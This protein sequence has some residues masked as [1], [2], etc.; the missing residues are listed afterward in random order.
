MDI[1]RLRK[2]R[3]YM[4]YLIAPD[5]LSPSEANHTINQI[6]A[7]KSLP[8][9]LYHDHFIGQAGGIIIFFAE[10]Q[11]EREA[12]QSGLEDYLVDWRYDVH[13]L[14]YSY[15]PAAFDAQIAYTLAAYRDNDWEQLQKEHRPTYGNL[16][17]EAETAEEVLD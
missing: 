15:N 16:S 3:C 11:A 2:P 6:C 5:N 4:V 13:P 9:A 7:D 8:L 1:T 17:Q 12:L 14:I 10:T